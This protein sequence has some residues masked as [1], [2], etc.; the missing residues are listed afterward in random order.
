MKIHIDRAGFLGGVGNLG[1]KFKM[2]T[3]IRLDTERQN[4]GR[5]G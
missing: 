4:I 1:L 3:F 5:N 2:D